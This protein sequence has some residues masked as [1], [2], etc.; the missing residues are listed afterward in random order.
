MI[1]ANSSIYEQQARAAKVTRFLASLDA[2]F[3][4]LTT[5]QDLVNLASDA[6]SDLNSVMERARIRSASQQTVDA[7]IARITARDSVAG[8]FEF[9]PFAKVAPR[10]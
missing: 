6:A 7:L 1:N 3:G 5:R 9:D 4:R 10:V 8:E 2:H